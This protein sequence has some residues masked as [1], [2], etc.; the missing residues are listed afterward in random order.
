MH[1]I[2]ATTTIDAPTAVVW[3]VLTDSGS[4]G[5]WNPFITELTGE[6]AQGRRLQIRIAPPGGRAMTFRPVVTAV[7]P[8]RRL[9]WLGRAGLPGL[10]DGA[11]SFTLAPLADGGTRFSQSEVFRGLLVPLMRATLRRTEAGFT[12]MNAA[13]RDR[14]ETAA[15]LEPRASGSAADVADPRH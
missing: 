8:G 12:A 15:R 5:T 9:A 13:L 11:H 7:D 14:A 4:Y 1:Q 2:S 10:F 6:I 3:A